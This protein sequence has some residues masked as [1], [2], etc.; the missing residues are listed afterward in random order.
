MRLLILNG[1]H[2]RWD[3]VDGGKGLE[4]ENKYISSPYCRI[5]FKDKNYIKEPEKKVIEVLNALFDGEEVVKIPVT[6]MGKDFTLNVKKKY[7]SIDPLV[8]TICGKICKSKAGLA[9]HIRK[10]KKENKDGNKKK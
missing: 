1:I 9:A 7:L 4:I 10:H 2:Y 8:C 3:V 6:R 5:V